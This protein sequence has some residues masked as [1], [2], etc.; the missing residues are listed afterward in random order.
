MRKPGFGT[1]SGVISEE[2][3]GQPVAGVVVIAGDLNLGTITDQYGYYVLTLPAGK[4]QLDLKYLGRKDQSIAISVTG[5]G[6]LNL[7]MAER[8][9]ELRGVVIS[10]EKDINV[11][12]LQLGFEKLDIQTIKQMS[13]TMGEGDLMKTALLLPGVKTVGEGAS[14]FN[15]RGGSTDQNLLLL[16]GSPVFNSSHMFG[17]FSVFNPDVVKEFRLYKSG[18][19]AQFG[20]RL[21]SVLDVNI[22]N[23]DL[24]KISVYGG[25]S[26]VA[27]RLTVDGPIIK[28]KASFLI[29]T[30]T[31]YSDWVLNRTKIPSLVNSNAS[32]LDLNA[33][34]D[35]S[36]NEKNHF[37]SSVYFSNDHFKLNSDTLYIYKNINAAINLKHTFSN[38]LYG[39][40]SAIY[41]NYSYSLSSNIRVPYAFDLNYFI[42]YLEGRTD[43]TWFASLKHKVTFGS[44]L[45]KYRI[46][47][48]SMNPDNQESMILPKKVADEQAFE[49]GIYINDEFNWT[50]ALS[51]SLGLRY[52]GFFS[53]G[54][55]MVYSYP[56]DAPRS[57]NNRI[58]SVYYGKNKITDVEGGPE[59]RFLVRYKTGNSSSVK[60]SYTKMN[61]YLQMMSNTTAISPTDIWKVSG[62]NLPAQ[63]SHQFSAGYYQYIMSNKILA[64]IEL[65]YK[66]AKN[67]LEYRGGT[68][69]V[70]NPDLEVDLLRGSGKNYGIEF[71]LKKEYGAL[72][73]WITYTYSRSLLKVDSKYLVDQINQGRYFPSNYDKPHDFT[74]VTNYRF[75]RIHSISTTITYC[76]GRPITYP[77]AKYRFRDRELIHYS[78]RN[79]YR[80]P[81]YFRWDM[82]L[83]FEGKLN[84]KKMWQNNMSISVY[85]ITG[86]ANAF[87]IFFVS[88]PKKG[89][90]G[91]KLSVFSQP[92]LTV[93]YDFKF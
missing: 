38:K 12:G 67:V 37:T 30:R 58:D 68:L 40:V 52:S 28:D 63:K 53:L 7:S 39:L 48:G 75:S 41:S 42:N 11:R 66:T 5:D 55:S 81:D 1:V 82:S 24:K 18:I 33:K 6:N 29:S 57:L 50:E 14:G 59:L 9:L 36:I 8:M 69:I 85:N 61:Q 10:A 32:F 15:V 84:R 23:G 65:Y 91:Y 17:F 31:S 46:N 34:I 60:F 45:I 20:G 21:S 13:F 3:S 90:K 86:R 93:T 74:I 49:T 51:M 88:D 16:D 83:N 80:I 62:P 2:E 77:V 64:S 25:I 35:I 89:V 76:T 73:G 56:Q 87:S 19:P 44:S 4:H 78:N 92:V 47:P 71:M 26:P 43:F 22:K 70:M 27:C 54:P 79:E 72:N